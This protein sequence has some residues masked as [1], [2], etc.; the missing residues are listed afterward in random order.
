MQYRRSSLKRKS[1][2]IWNK[3]DSFVPHELIW[4]KD[5]TQ[6]TPWP[7]PS[8]T[9]GILCGLAVA[10]LLFKKDT[11]ITLTFEGIRT[12][13]L[14]HICLRALAIYGITCCYGNLVTMATEACVCDFAI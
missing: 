12:S 9:C 13:H 14:V 6:R 11:F 7:T 3:N 4:V 2:T 10:D 8:R 1:S 5:K